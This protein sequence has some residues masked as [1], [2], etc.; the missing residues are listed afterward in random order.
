VFTARYALSPY[1]KQ[2]RFVFKGLNSAHYWRNVRIFAPIRKASWVSYI[3]YS[4]AA[5]WHGSAAWREV[6][7]LISMTGKQVYGND[8]VHFTVINFR[9]RLECMLVAA[10]TNTVQLAYIQPATYGELEHEIR[11]P[12]EIRRRVK[13]WSVP[14]VPKQHH[15]FIL[16][17]LEF[18]KRQN[19]Q[20]FRKH[21]D[22]SK[23]RE[24]TT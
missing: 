18:R 6:L 9:K 8:S 20:T 3:L 12:S 23:R 10:L 14:D 16:N 1:I 5:D 4:N 17:G 15:A 11:T 21:Y 22:P 19:D 24:L 7:L 2:I 13:R